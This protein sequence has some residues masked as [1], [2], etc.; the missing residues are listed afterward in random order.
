MY[1]SNDCYICMQELDNFKIDKCNNIEYYEK[2]LYHLPQFKRSNIRFI[3]PDKYQL[4]CGHK[5]CYKCI[6]LSINSCGNKCPYCRT[7]ISKKELTKL[8]LM[9][10]Q[11]Y[12]IHVDPILITGLAQN[13]EFLKYNK[14]EKLTRKKTKLFRTLVIK[15]F[16]QFYLTFLEDF[17]DG[18]NHTEEEFLEV[19]SCK[20]IIIYIMIELVRKN[21]WFLESNKNF[22]KTFMSKLDEIHIYKCEQGYGYDN[23]LSNF[24][25][26][27]LQSLI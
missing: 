21:K 1:G 8:Y 19:N 15:D 7:K 12:Q 2:F 17:I 3:S 11:N 9:F 18:Y 6:M 13:K 23:I 10:Y 5:T 26:N 20:S 16:I 24:W 14:I 22:K 4:E 25:K 27:E